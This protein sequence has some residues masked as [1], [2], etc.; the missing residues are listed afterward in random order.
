MLFISLR[1]LGTINDSYMGISL[2]AIIV[3]MTRFS[4][5]FLSLNCLLDPGLQ[6]YFRACF[7]YFP[8]S[9]L[10]TF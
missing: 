3:R 8:T 4:I 9:T 2:K 5:S 7:W 10:G 1:Y 6:V